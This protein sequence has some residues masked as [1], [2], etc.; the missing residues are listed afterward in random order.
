MHQAIPQLLKLPFDVMVEVSEY[1]DLCSRTCLMDSCRSMRSLFLSSHHLWKQIRID[2][3]LY[4]LHKLYSS[5]RKL[6]DSNGL[7]RHV[8]E[9]RMDDCDDP[10]FSPLVMLMKFPSLKCISATHRKQTTNL[11]VD[12]KFLQDM[13]KFGRILPGSLPIERLNLYHHSMEYEEFLDTYQKTW[14]R[15]SSH[16]HVQLD[17]RTCNHPIEQNHPSSP[18]GCLRII[19]SGARCWSCRSPFD[20][21]YR[22]VPLCSGCQKRR[23]PPAANEQQTQ[24][25]QKIK[26]DS[27][28]D[29]FSL[30]E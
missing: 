15:I 12:I 26:L 30:F 29:D 18:P 13:L 25:K 10:D 17:I 2:L 9:V 11:L 4:D 1:L 6:S 22:C 27:V 21:C 14:N 5:L 7:H 3:S 23:I 24:L 20:T 8:Q 16:P 28:Q 19:Q